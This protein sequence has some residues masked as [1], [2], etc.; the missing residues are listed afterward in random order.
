MTLYGVYKSTEIYMLQDKSAD[1]E[2]TWAFLDRRLGDFQTL[3]AAKKSVSKE[4][5]NDLQIKFFPSSSL[6]IILGC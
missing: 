6:S 1:K 4:F 3:A 5:D 2:D